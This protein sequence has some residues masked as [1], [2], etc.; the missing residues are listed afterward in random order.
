MLEEWQEASHTGRIMTGKT[1]RG[2]V[3]G[4]TSNAKGLSNSVSDV[5]EAVEN[6]EKDPYEVCSGE[7]LLSRV[8]AANKKAL[9]RRDEWMARRIVKI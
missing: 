2:I 6:G 7:D 1:F 8:H 4:C 5:L 9:A 3:T